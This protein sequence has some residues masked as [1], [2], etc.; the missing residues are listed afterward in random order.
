MHKLEN[1]KKNDKH[2]SEEELPPHRTASEGVR[3]E[4]MTHTGGAQVHQTSEE[5][6]EEEEEGEC[7][8]NSPELER[9]KSD[10]DAV[11]MS[12]AAMNTNNVL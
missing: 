6:E 4:R 9:S 3:V 12:V 5:E 10:D 2:V 11:A 7:G 1:A 8:E